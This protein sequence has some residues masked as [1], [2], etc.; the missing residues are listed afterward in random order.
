MLSLSQGKGEQAPR[1]TGA[2]EGASGAASRNPGLLFPGSGVLGA[3]SL[4][5]LLSTRERGAAKGGDP[6]T[7]SQAL[8]G[9]VC[10]H[11]YICMCVHFV[12]VHVNVCVQGVQAPAGS[13]LPLSVRPFFWLPVHSGHGSVGSPE[14]CP[15]T[16]SRLHLP[17]QEAFVGSPSIQPLCPPNIPCS[18]CTA[19]SPRR[20]L[21]PSHL[22]GWRRHAFCW[23]PALCMGWVTR[24]RQTTLKK[25]K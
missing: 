19:H 15:G 6:E 23:V 8:E 5:F 12:Y 14:P 11:M 4:P 24:E 7:G 1:V 2:D 3:G 17:G 20:G 25:V 18:V 10:A 16:G 21:S 22:M 13:E 9:P